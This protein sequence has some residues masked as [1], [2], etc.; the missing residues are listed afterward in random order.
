MKKYD[1]DLFKILVFS[2]E[3]RAGTLSGDGFIVPEF[4]N[5]PLE[6]IPGKQ[7]SF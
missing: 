7:F 5:S 4:E 1:V 2:V 3:C 6:I